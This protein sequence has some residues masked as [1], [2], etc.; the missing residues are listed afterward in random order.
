MDVKQFEQEIE[1][2]DAMCA[3]ILLDRSVSYA[4]E[5][6]LESFK[7]IKLLTGV[8]APMVCAVLQAKHIV[9]LYKAISEDRYEGLDKYIVDIINYQRLL[10]A[11]IVEEHTEGIS[12]PGVTIGP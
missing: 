12:T 2:L 5:D 10:K 4:G 1:Q 9:A 8:P 6:R 7:Q 11:I 3:D